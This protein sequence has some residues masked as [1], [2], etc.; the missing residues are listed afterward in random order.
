MSPVGN[1]P[2]IRTC[3]D[4]CGVSADARENR[5]FLRKVAMSWVLPGKWSR[6]ARAVQT[7]ISCRDCDT[8][9]QAVHT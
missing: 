6:S 2:V 9:L 5:Y 8:P 1:L 3:C 7:T 4:Q